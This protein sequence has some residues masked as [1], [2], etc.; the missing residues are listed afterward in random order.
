MIINQN[1]NDV[2]RIGEQTDTK[3]ATINA[4]KMSKLQHMLTSGLYNDPISACMVEWSNNAIDSIIQSGKDPIQNPSI[5]NLSKQDNTYYLTITDKGLGLNKDEF[6]NVVMN[7]L[8][9]TKENA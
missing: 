4:D 7:Y 5:V 6:E 3:Q 9:S 8:T 1:T 2:L